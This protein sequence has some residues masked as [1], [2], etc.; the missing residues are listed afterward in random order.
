V[1]APGRDVLWDVE[2][3]HASGQ[4]LSRPVVYLLL[5]YAVVVLGLNWPI[6]TTG[7]RS[8]TPIW[9]ASFRTG[10]AALVV[11]AAAAATR[12]IVIPPRRDVPMILSIAIFRLATLM[13]LVFFALRLLPAG[14][15][16]VLVWTTALWTVPIA[17]VFLGE[18]ISAQKWVGLLV[19]LGGIVVI[20]EVWTNNW[21]EPGVVVGT[22]LLLLG[23]IVNASTAVH[24]KRHRW[25]IT[26]LQALPWQLVG[27]A[28][29]L[30][31]LA[32]LVDGV[33]HIEWTPQLVGVLLYQAGLATGTA[34]L[35]QIVVLRNLSA[36]STN[37]SMMGVPLIGV[38]SSAVVLGETVT[39]ALLIGM[40]L[41]LTGVSINLLSDR[42]G[43]VSAAPQ[44]TTI[45]PPTT[46]HTRRNK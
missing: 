46:A 44:A 14:R 19:G 38:V 11:G 12:N 37:L 35:A 17:A 40:A 36:V 15:A 10:G 13:T 8:I 6:M 27:A 33:P 22:G 34:F 9:M 42:S 3:P 45:S 39:A 32:L 29:P 5:V 24:I 43:P 21:R 7:L 26:P 16:S 28:V 30:T 31:L 2:E 1:S 41:V 18:R 23:S 25:T 20:S 4:H